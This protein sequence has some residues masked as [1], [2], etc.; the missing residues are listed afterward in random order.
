MTVKRAEN[1]GIG[2]DDASHV[3][4]Y[5]GNKT[6]STN[7]PGKGPAPNFGDTISFDVDDDSQP[8]IVNVNSNGRSILETQV[9]FDNIKEPDFPIN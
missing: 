6:S 4:M 7:K 8:L 2:A 1:L 5:Q 3:V 9:S